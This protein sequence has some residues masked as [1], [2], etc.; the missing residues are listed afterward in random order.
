MENK[1]NPYHDKS[2][3]FTS[4]GNAGHKDPLMSLFGGLRE[5]METAHKKEDD[6]ISKIKK[7]G[8]EPKKEEEID[9]ETQRWLDAGYS[10]RMHEYPTKVYVDE[11]D[12]YGVDVFDEDIIE[13]LSDDV[14]LTEE[15]K[16]DIIYN[17]VIPYR[18]VEDG[19]FDDEMFKSWILE[20]NE[21]KE[22]AEEVA[23]G[24]SRQRL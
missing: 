14:E 23:E 11:F 6:A 7:M 20:R 12:N 17:K 21:E 8:F 15:E 4:K 9:E 24:I 1:G 3:K 19:Y 13:Y 2:G 10:E 5:S 18:F 16:D 22:A